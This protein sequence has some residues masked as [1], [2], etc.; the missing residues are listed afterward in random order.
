[1]ERSTEYQTQE[2]SKLK[3]NERENE[4]K[5]LTINSKQTKFIVVSKNEKPEMLAKIRRR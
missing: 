4:K 3:G 1:M 5:G 2:F